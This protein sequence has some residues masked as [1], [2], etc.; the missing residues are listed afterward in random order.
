MWKGPYANERNIK[1]NW[2]NN[3]TMDRKIKSYLFYL[4]LIFFGIVF[5]YIV[6]NPFISEGL[7]INLALYSLGK[8]AG[9]IGFLF[10]D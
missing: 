9:L 7:S 4:C 5:T 10:L 1:S 6:F 8:L 3:W 2:V